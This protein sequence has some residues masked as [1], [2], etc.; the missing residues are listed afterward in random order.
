MLSNLLVIL[1]DIQKDLNVMTMRTIAA[2]NAVSEMI[3][4]VCGVYAADP[5]TS[6]KNWA[7]AF[8]VLASAQ[9]AFIDDCARLE[10]LL[11]DKG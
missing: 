2:N 1:Q 9:E 8:G 3:N 10:K 4:S 7:S 5:S 11:N 6:A